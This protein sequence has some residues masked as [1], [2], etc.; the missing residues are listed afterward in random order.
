MNLMMQ[1]VG[2]IITDLKDLFPCK[3]VNLFNDS[4]PYGLKIDKNMILGA[5]AV[6]QGELTNKFEVI[7]KIDQ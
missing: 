5:V 6:L 7:N 2:G 4:E 3:F 1:V